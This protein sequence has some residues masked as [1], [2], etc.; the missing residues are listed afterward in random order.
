MDNQEKERLAMATARMLQGF[1]HTETIMLK[2]LPTMMQCDDEC[3]LFS[4][5]GTIVDAYADTYN[6]SEE[7]IREMYSMTLEAREAIYR[8]EEG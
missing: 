5:M 2:V 3:E 6:I 8:K 4:I 1:H 7:R